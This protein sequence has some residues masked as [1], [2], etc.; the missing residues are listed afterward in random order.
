MSNDLLMNGY[1]SD[2][3][4]FTATEHRMNDWGHS[5]RDFGLHN[6][7]QS[8]YVLLTNAD[9]YYVPVFV[10]EIVKAVESNKEIR[11]SFIYYN[12]I[13]NHDN[14]WFIPSGS[15]GMLNTQLSKSWI[16]IGSAVVK[17]SLAKKTGFTH[18]NYEADW[19]YFS[20]C[21]INLSKE[22]T[23]EAVHDNLYNKLFNQQLSDWFCV[24]NGV[25]NLKYQ[26]DFS[27]DGTI[28]ID[29]REVVKINKILFVHN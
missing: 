13:H 17:T 9:N 22:F 26:Q 20:D 27:I 16:D 15:Y 3:I 6:Y 5:V 12:C 4:Q 23:Q 7:A 29:P 10:E 18:R 8:E 1:L 25:H 28:L 21:L 2:T 11:P 19:L 24:K 14:L